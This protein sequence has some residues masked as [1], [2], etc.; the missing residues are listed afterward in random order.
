MTTSASAQINAGKLPPITDLPFVL[1]PVAG[2]N[3]PWRLAFLP[4][5]RMLVTEKVGPI[6]LVT[7]QVRNT[8]ANVPPV[9]YQNQN[10]MLGVFLSPHYATDHNVYLTYTEPGTYGGGLALA[11][12]KLS[13]T[14]TSASLDGLEV[15]WRQLPTGM[16]GQDGAQVAFSPDGK[17]LFLTVG[18]RQRMTALP[19]P[20]SAG[21]ENSAIDPGRQARAGQ[22]HGLHR[23]ADHSSDRS[24]ERYR[25]G[26]NC[27]CG[28][29]LYLLDPPDPG[30]P[31]Q[32]PSHALWPGL[33]PTADCGRPSMVPRAAMN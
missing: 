20:Q 21:R 1:T 19:G 24:A 15:L 4:D 14:A 25:S 10:G 23:G 7:Q 30:R 17:Y 22:S 29:H 12:A 8:V 16:G 27:A 3:L 9:Y 6:W 32:R 13:L 28:Q 2:F 33:R 11:R 18:D 5:G 26:K 31:D